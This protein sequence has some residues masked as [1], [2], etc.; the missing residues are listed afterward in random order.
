MGFGGPVDYS[1]C[2]ASKAY[3]RAQLTFLSG[4]IFL[5]RKSG[6]FGKVV[7][8]FFLAWMVASWP[9]AKRW[10]VPSPMVLT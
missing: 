5:F 6:V 10:M 4:L 1:C 3:P 9:L 2:P 8:Q 7:V